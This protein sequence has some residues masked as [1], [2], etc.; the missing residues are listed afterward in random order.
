MYHDTKDDIIS[1]LNKK[2]TH[3]IR[4]I[5]FGIVLD[6]HVYIEDLTKFMQGHGF[7][8]TNVITSPDKIEWCSSADPA[9][10]YYYHNIQEDHWAVLFTRH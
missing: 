7:V 4:A 6:E 8:P 9:D 5:L 10:E 1:V 3:D 2:I